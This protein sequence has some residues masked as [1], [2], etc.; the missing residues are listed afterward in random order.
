VRA[1]RLPPAQFIAAALRALPGERDEQIASGIVTR[2]TT[3]ESR[4]L[5]A[6]Q[7][8]SLAAAA[9]QTLLAGAADSSRAYG[10]RKD[11]LDAYIA[12]ARTPAAMAHIAAWLD[13]GSAAGL[14]LLQPTRWSIVSHLLERGE[15]AA[16]ALLAA[17]TRHDTTT[18]AKRS[19]F[20]VGAARP[21]PRTKQEYFARYFRDSTLNEDWATAS[22]RTFSAVDD[23]TLTLPYLIP[24]LD[25]LQWI[26]KN[27]RIFFLGSWIGG[28]VGG[29]RSPHALSAIDN[30]LAKRPTLPLDLRQKILQSRD[31]LERTVR[32]RARYAG[33]ADAES[34]VVPTGDAGPAR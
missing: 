28:F 1:A 11:Q 30:F 10:V 34:R 17:E 13:S 16:D 12:T 31:D 5:S 4:Y 24:A 15:R 3:A 21:T 25:S 6:E 18:G 29:Q 2:I 7:Q 33:G 14:R 9:E 32:I 27:R 8:R 19:A 26:Q 22:L 20:V 23:D